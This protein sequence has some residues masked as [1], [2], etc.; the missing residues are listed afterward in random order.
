MR[1]KKVLVLSVAM[2]LIASMFPTTVFGTGG[3]ANF[4]YS[5]CFRGI[6]I[7]SPDAYRVSAFI[8][9]SHLG[10][11][12]FRSPQDLFVFENLI[13]VVDS[14]NN[15][16]VVMEYTEDSRHVVYEVVYYV[17]LDGEPSYF[18]NPHGIFVA[19]NG[20][21]WIADTFNNRMLKTDREWNVLKEVGHPE[22]SM[23]DEGLDF[24]PNK[25]G[26]DIS[27]RLFVQ[28]THVN[29]G[30]MEFCNQGIFAGYMGAAPVWIS[31]V[32]RFWR[33]VAT[34]AQRER[35]ILFTPTEYSNVH[36]D[37]EGFIFVT[38]ASPSPQVEALRRLNAMGSDI[39][40]RNG[41]HPIVGDITTGT[42][43]GISGPSRFIDVTSLPNETFVAFD[44]TRGRM[45][46][47]DF[48]GNLLYVF[49]GRGNREGMFMLPA[50]L[51]SMGYAL[52]A[53]DAH[54]GAVTR[55]DLTEY[56]VLINDA[57]A[58]Y[59]MGRYDE[60]LV[61]WHEVLRVNGN[62]GIAYIGIARALLRQGYY[63]EAMRYFRLN[64]D[65]VGYGRAFGFYRRQWM[66]EN[67][68]IFVVIIATLFIV[69]P[70]VRK[71]RTVR[72]NVLAS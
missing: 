64:D 57:M 5:Y 69:P 46:K 53:L 43:A 8:L 24:L 71:V 29:R 2:I 35:M 30:L 12:D 19:R 1:F 36:V 59:R 10:V 39:L 26:A 51:C 49:G 23:L 70:V 40:I 47:Y 58:L 48:Q 11:G 4:T 66:E 44:R 34:P 21:I 28:A 42:A 13:F 72:R 3:F 7:P 56:G 62:F 33:M 15:R 18:N 14:G 63:R 41:V 52:Y 61:Y 16:I 50:A 25:L 55:F 6:P 17:N 32:D 9:G 60:S 20:D 27:G 68:A 67:F 45:F 31:P 65:F 38:N 54:S 37:R 22:E